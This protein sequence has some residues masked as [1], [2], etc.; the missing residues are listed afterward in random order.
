MPA[1]HYA[2]ADFAEYGAPRVGSETVCECLSRR[3][4][5]E[6]CSF[7]SAGGELVTFLLITSTKPYWL[8]PPISSGWFQSK[9]QKKVI[10]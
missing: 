5:K 2:V 7:Y 6:E 4:G 1:R 8:Y 3:L 9:K 10:L